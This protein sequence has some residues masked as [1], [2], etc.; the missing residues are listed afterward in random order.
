MVLVPDLS[1]IS[2][3][4][5]IFPWPCFLVRVAPAMIVVLIVIVIAA[6]IVVGLYAQFHNQWQC[7]RYHITRITRALVCGYHVARGG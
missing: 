3:P 2:I 6:V 4:G 1:G 7:R 5:E